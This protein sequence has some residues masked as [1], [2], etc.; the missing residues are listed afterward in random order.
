M[1]FRYS[2]MRHY[3][4]KCEFLNARTVK[5]EKQMKK[6][7]KRFEQLQFSF[8]AGEYVQQMEATGNKRRTMIRRL[9]SKIFKT[10]T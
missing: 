2:N 4:S 10:I 5:A 1:L 6:Y 3:E 7:K 8:V 9:K